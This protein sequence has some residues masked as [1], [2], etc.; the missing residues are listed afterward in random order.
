MTPLRFCRYGFVIEDRM[1][2]RACRAEDEKRILQER[3]RKDV[4][5]RIGTFSLIFGFLSILAQGP[6][7]AG[8]VQRPDVA[9]EAEIVSV[10]GEGRIRFVREKEWMDAAR[11]QILASGRFDQDGNYGR[12]SLLFVDDS[13]IKVHNRT[14]LMIK[15]VRKPGDK[16]GTLLRLESGEVWSRAKSVHESLRIET[17][18]ATAAIRGTEWDIVVDEKGTSYLTVLRGSVELFN[19]FWTSGGESRGTGDN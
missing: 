11:E 1:G 15:K 7:N 10:Q 17:P 16:T 13:Q 6:A 2:I 5:K 18:S 4:L 12:M 8:P 9:K 3:S 14:T 19:D